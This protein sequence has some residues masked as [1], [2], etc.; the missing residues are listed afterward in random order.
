VA[1]KAALKAV[2]VACGQ[3]KNI[4]KEMYRFYKLSLVISLRDLEGDCTVSK[5]YTRH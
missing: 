1:E 5:N 4:R 3:W 2:Q